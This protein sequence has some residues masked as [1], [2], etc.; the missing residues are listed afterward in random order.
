MSK[1]PLVNTSGRGSAAARAAASA[2]EQ[3]FASK[4]GGG[5]IV[6]PPSALTPVSRSAASALDLEKPHHPPH[7]ARGARELGRIVRFLLL[8]DAHEIDGA[9]LGDDFDVNR[10]ELARVDEARLHFRS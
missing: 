4:I 9:V 7:A 6:F 10:V 8:D 2:G 1:T 5:W 3:S